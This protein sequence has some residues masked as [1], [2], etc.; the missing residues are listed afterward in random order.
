MHRKM[1]E[2]HYITSACEQTRPD[3]HYKG[4]MITHMKEML[5]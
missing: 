4:R 3:V 1:N 2:Y 5:P